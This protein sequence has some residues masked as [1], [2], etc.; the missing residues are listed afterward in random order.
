M[1]KQTR[2]YENKK[3]FFTKRVLCVCAG[4]IVAVFVL[5]L[6]TSAVACSAISQY[7]TAVAEFNSLVDEYNQAAFLTS[8]DNV[9][10][11]PTSVDKLN[12]ESTSL[13]EGLSV[14]F[15]KNSIQKIHSDTQTVY[16]LA[17]QLRDSMKIIKQ[18][19]A[20]DT[21]WVENR[22]KS[23]SGVTNA[24]A[25]TEQNNPDGLLE[26]EGGYIGCVYFAYDKIDAD[27]ILGTSVVE[28]GT[29]AGGAVEIYATLAEAEARCEYL[30]GFD[31]TVLYS[32]SY[33][34]VGTTVIRTS[35]LLTNEEQFDLTNALT[36]ALTK[37]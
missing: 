8:V 26:K 34:I 15:G 14:I 33:A 28:K 11:V 6:I 27:A 5:L 29:D 16:D 2:C 23:V 36:Q 32:G 21:A 31:D 30:S 24:E 19:T 17:N 12:V 7:N 22:I 25:V 13:F 37:E 35:Y 9:I 18:I 10:G 4:V 3:P 1:K 20:P